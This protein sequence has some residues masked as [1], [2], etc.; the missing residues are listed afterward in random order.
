MTEFNKCA[1]PKA[2][3]ILMSA[4]MLRALLD[5][6]KTQT[7]RVV[8]PKP[9][10]DFCI[11]DPAIGFRFKGGPNMQCPYGK[12]G[13][14]LWVRETFAD[15]NDH[16]CPAILYNADRATLDFMQHEEYHCED[17]SLDYDHPH[18]KKYYYLQWIGDVESGEPHH[19]WKPSIHMPRWASRLTLE[20]TDVRVERL[21]EISEED[22]DAEGVEVEWPYHQ[23]N[24]SGDGHRSAFRVLWESIFGDGS[25]NSN[26]WVWVLTFG[27]HQRNVAELQRAA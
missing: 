3:P 8:K 11:F 10:S 24:Y 14:L 23:G 18:I 4:P 21:Q 16:G 12:P 5:G 13:E 9:D 2:R 19:G 27:I 22:A 1:S 6:R 17:G 20:L 26:P 25:W 7:R 15:V